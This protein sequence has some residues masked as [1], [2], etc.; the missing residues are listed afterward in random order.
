M[1]ASFEGANLTI[2]LSEFVTICVYL[3][4]L[5]KNYFFFMQVHDNPIV[6][7]FSQ[8]TKK[9]KAKVLKKTQPVNGAKQSP[10]RMVR[11]KMRMMNPPEVVEQPRKRKLHRQMRKTA[12]M[13]F[14]R[15]DVLGTEEEEKCEKVEEM[16][17]TRSPAE[18]ARKVETKNRGKEKTRTMTKTVTKMKRRKRT[19][20]MLTQVVTR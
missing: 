16:G 3:L 9:Q 15:G 4:L 13:I 20:G 5:S 12:M 8:R 7:S 6:F 14:H 18:K 10:V 1:T 11:M 17:K 19:V 2:F